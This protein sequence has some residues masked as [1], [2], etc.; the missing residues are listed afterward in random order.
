MQILRVDMDQLSVSRQ[1]LPA[2]Y[3]NWA[4]RGLTARILQREVPP[5]CAPLGPDNRL[6]IANGFFAGTRLSSAGRISVGAKSPLTGGIKESNSGGIAGD[7]MARLGLRAII[8]QGAPTTNNLYVLRVGAEKAELIPADEYRRLGTFSLCEKLYERFGKN[9]AV[10]CIGPAGEHRLGA[11]GVAVNDN[12]GAPAR[13]AGRGGLGAVMGAKGIKAVVLDDVRG[14]IPFHDREA[15]REAQKRFNTALLES[16]GAKNFA[17]YGT[18]SML[19][20]IHKLGGVPTKN[21]SQGTF[22]EHYPNLSSEGVRRFILE[23]GGEGTPTHACMPGCIVRCSNVIPD[24]QG[25]AIVSPLEYENLVML[26]PNLGIFSI[27]EIARLNYLCNDYGLDTIEAGASL[28]V[29]MEAGLLSFGDFPGA[30]NLMRQIAAGTVVGRV[31]GHGAATVGKVFGV[32]RVPTV[33]GQGL[34][35]YDPRA[36]KGLGVTYLTSPMG[37]DHTA[38]HTIAAKV[39][40]H[41]PEGQIEA[42]LD[43]QTRVAGMDTVCICSFANA[44]LRNAELLADMLRAAHGMEVG[45]DYLIETGRKVLNMERAFNAAAGFTEAD[46]RYHDFFR[47]EKL[48]PFDVTFDVPQEDI[49]RAIE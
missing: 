42:S 22:D 46:N 18:I 49:D 10:V 48:P 41:L 4:G 31:V 36:V 40:H 9:V 29:A 7:A 44:P 30:V 23:R 6:I 21:F 33:K 11:A 19:D 17:D 27:D 12:D 13:Y 28:G 2:E 16:P 24:A 25:K 39:D 47:I 38:G 3:Q 1:D 37:A 45:H 5:T 14:E 32:S 34:P 8:V 20:R 15:F 26:G 43:A 35:A